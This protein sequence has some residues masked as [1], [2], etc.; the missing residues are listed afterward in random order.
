MART[1]LRPTTP[2]SASPSGN[3]TTPAPMSLASPK[4]RRPSWVVAGVAMIALAALLGAW[5]FTAT[6]D[7]MRVV[8]AARD[9]TPGEVIGSSDLR[10]VEL[11]R[12][13]G[14][15]AIAPAQ[16]DLVVGHAA[17][18][19]IPAGT[20][21]NTDLFADRDRVI[22]AG[23]AV[24]GASLPA[25]AIPTAG[26]AAGDRVDVLGVVKSTGAPADA[27]AAAS[28]LTAGTVWSVER[29]SSTGGSSG[30]WVSV[31]IPAES[32][33]AV[34]QAAADGRLRLSLVGASG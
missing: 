29:P 16:Q 21:L 15:R 23:S 25:G 24:V 9:L 2:S 34:A 18:G 13:G 19:P 14:V 3:G 26:L 10:V 12:T 5:V 1:L 6:S 27:E 4:H 22:P 8:V 28:R 32:Q 30:W 7:T 33:A 31:L 20:V 17:R 11:G